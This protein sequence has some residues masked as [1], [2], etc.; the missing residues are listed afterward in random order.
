MEL[1]KLF[2]FSN[3]LQNKQIKD[4]L[5]ADSNKPKCPHCGGPTE[6]GYTR[7]KNCGQ[8]IAWVG[9]VACKP[10]NLSKVKAKAENARRAEEILANKIRFQ[11]RRWYAK[12][13]RVLRI[14]YIVVWIVLLSFTVW[15]FM[16]GIETLERFLG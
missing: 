15:L 4:Q 6:Q 1:W 16:G 5:S 3:Y 13:G 14:S 7:C 8:K 12:W 11:E 9:H 2:G 10:G